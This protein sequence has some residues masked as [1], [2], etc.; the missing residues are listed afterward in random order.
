[1]GERA[2]DVERIVSQ[3]VAAL[4]SQ[5]HVDKVILF[6]SRARGEATD[7][8]DIDLLIISSDFGR[9]IL[10]DYTLLYRCMPLA[11]V[12]IDVIPH[13][14]GQIAA[15]EPETFLATALEDGVV[16]YPRAG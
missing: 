16:V 6:G 14:P 10:A 1:M 13:T 4:S 3:F 8:S 9:D 15:A 11:P 2:P 5:V 12:D 7:D